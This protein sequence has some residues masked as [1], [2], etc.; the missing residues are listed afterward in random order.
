MFFL[1][2]TFEKTGKIVF[3]VNTYK[4]YS[5]GFLSLSISDEET[6]TTMKNLY[7]KE[8]YSN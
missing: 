1:K 8:K 5:K 4:A 6:L 2:N 3:D 7:K